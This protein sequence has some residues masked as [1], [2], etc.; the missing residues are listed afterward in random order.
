MA[1][2]R[3]PGAASGHGV[4]SAGTQSTDTHGLS[5]SCCATLLITTGKVTGKGG[6][7]EA[8][9]ERGMGPQGAEASLRVS[10]GLFFLPRAPRP[11]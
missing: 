9:M 1:G 2:G 7:A 8:G 6:G 3:P 11:A 5:S 4:P 10:G